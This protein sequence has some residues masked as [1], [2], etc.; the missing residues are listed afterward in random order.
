MLKF[1]IISSLFHVTILIFSK[2]DLIDLSKKK[3]QF[4]NVGIIE[5]NPIIKKEMKKKE[6]PKPKKEL[7]KKQPPK[8]KKELKRKQPPKPKK[9]TK[10]KIKNPKENQKKFDDML[11]DLA[12]NKLSEEVNNYDIDKTIEKLSEQNILEK[13]AVKNNLELS[14]IINLIISQIDANW[15]RPP[16]I[17]ISKNLTIKLIIFLDINGEVINLE[18][19]KKTKD[20]INSN[21]YLQP[22][23]DSAIRAIKKSSP[24][25]G[26]RKDRYNVWKELIINFK[27]IE[28]R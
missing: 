22:Y 28:T 20:N 9:E 1:I 15:S 10:K 12:K 27:P 24:F 25:E 2:L 6:P 13:E 14:K 26:L 19:H 3:E 16:G 17:K 18:V 11:K 8:P 5:E 7:K 23:L 21:Q 4:V